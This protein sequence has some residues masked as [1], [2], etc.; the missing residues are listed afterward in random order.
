MRSTNSSMYSTLFEKEVPKDVPPKCCTDLKGETRL[1]ESCGFN[2]RSLI[3]WSRLMIFS[4]ST[5][6]LESSEDSRSRFCRR[7]NKS[8][9]VTTSLRSFLRISEQ[10]NTSSSISFWLK[11]LWTCTRSFRNSWKYMKRQFSVCLIMHIWE[12]TN[13]AIQP[14]HY[15]P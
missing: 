4:S 5:S 11:E 6:K 12:I 7:E 14:Y 1:H 15:Q 13:L 8:L 10:R 3:S 9:A 2:C